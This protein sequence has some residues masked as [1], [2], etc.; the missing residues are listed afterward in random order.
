MIRR[1][2]TPRP[3]ALWKQIEDAK[4]V[5]AGA[6]SG[7]ASARGPRQNSR[8]RG[9]R[10]SSRPRP[11]SKL[12]D[13]VTR[14]YRAKADAFLALQPRPHGFRGRLE[15]HHTRGRLGT[16]LIDERFWLG[17][18][19]KTHRWIHE[20]PKDAVQRGL[21]CKP[22]EWNRAPRDPETGRLQAILVT[23]RP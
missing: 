23:L 8:A 16:L 19:P 4:T 12:L 1:R 21:L 20:H 6:I 13:A 3:R 15:L 14:Y 18:T 7:S 2:T 5:D 10:R 9:V 17:V 11:R 22:G